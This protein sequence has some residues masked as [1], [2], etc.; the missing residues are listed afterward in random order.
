VE[1]DCYA[2]EATEANRTLVEGEKVWLE[3][4]RFNTSGD[5]ALTRDVW[6]ATDAGGKALVAVELVAQGAAVPEIREPDNRFAAWLEAASAEAQANDAG[7]WGACGGIAA[8]ESSARQASPTVWALRGPWR[9]GV[10]GWS[11]P[12]G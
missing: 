12:R 7:L 9:R 11:A 8:G 4:Q 1:D 2:G 3:R 10:D 6:V 5:D